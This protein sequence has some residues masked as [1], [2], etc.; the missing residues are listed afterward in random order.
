MF[1]LK[2]VVIFLAGAEFFHTFVHIMLAYANQFPLDMKVVVLT[3]TIN[4]WGIIIN[5]LITIALLLWAS[6]LPK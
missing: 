4:M 5:A 6:R 3:S 1:T 2:N